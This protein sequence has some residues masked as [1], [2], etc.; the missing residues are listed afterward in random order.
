MGT[1]SEERERAEALAQRVTV[2]IVTALPKEHVAVKAMLDGPVDHDDYVLGEMPAKGGGTHVVALLR[3][4]M[5]TTLAAAKTAKLLAEIKTIDAIL[6]VGIAGGVP[7]TA[8]PW[9]H[10]R[11]GDIVVLDHHGVIDTGHVS[12]TRSDGTVVTEHRNPP[13]APSPRLLDAVDDL[14]GAEHEGKQPWLDLIRRG[15]HS[16]TAR[17]RR[18]RPTSCSAVKCIPRTASGVPASHASSTERSLHRRCC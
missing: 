17:G 16:R 13:R 12:V 6:M 11:L 14:I 7:N 8:V 5:G 4:G 9:D 2:G 10:V 15:D 18:R 1:A 3:T